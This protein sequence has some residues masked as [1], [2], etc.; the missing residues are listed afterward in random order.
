MTLFRR[1]SAFLWLNLTLV[2]VGM[3]SPAQAH[4]LGVL[5]AD[6]VESDTATGSDYALTVWLTA[7]PLERVFQPPDL[8]RRCTLREAEV[9]QNDSRRDF[10][11]DCESRL[12]NLDTF[13]LHWPIDGLLLK[14]SWQNA[15]DSKA[16]FAT[17]NG[18]I[19]INLS[20][21]GAGS[22]TTAAQVGT[23]FELGIRHI[24]G[25]IDHLF[26]V[27][28]LL[29]LMSSRRRLLATI[30]AFTVGH[31]VTL[32]MTTLGDVQVPVDAL[33]ACIA[34]S[35]VVMAYEAVRLQDGN[36]GLCVRYPWSM[37]GAFG[38]LHGFGFAG[39]LIELEL[40]VSDLPL[41]LLGFNLG[42]EAGQI[43]FIALVL[44]I[45]G[46]TLRLGPFFGSFSG[47]RGAAYTLGIV[48]T[49]W[50]MQRTLPLI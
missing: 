49:C 9:H 10:I 48:A 40:E 45:Y 38:L 13:I 23:Y 5:K 41:A 37:A 46:S 8:P 33:E 14:A 44:L 43:L 15:P 12:T 4:D 26:F 3:F 30:T 27:T 2:L 25:G 36:P 6:L 11:F 18:E 24:L 47:R 34:L 29:L 7:K 32:L 20:A 28:G 19:T 42:V 1:G 31:S 16:V 39:A 35:V 17:D 22:A 21:L 50:T